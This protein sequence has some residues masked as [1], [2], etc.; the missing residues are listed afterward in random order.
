MFSPVG[1]AAGL[2]ARARL[3]ICADNNTVPFGLRKGT[4]SHGM[5]PN[6][7][8]DRSM[9]NDP[10]WNLPAVPTFSL[11]SADVTDGGEVPPELYSGFAGVPGGRD[12]SPQLSWEG[13]PAGTQSYVVTMFDPD[14]PT[15]SGYWHWAVLGIPAAV[16]SLP[17]GAGDISGSQLPSGAVQLRNDAG[18]AG[19]FGSA[20]PPGHG[21]HRYVIV[22]HAA[23][24]ADLG[25][26]VDA[27]PA[28]LGFALFTHT[29]ARAAITVIG[30]RAGY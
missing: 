7:R 16:T 3:R 29:L 15:G 19:F 25:V 14:A 27:S 26:S 4:S 2:T 28:A 6:A 9:S 17:R 20:P 18:L 13:A 22:V 10:F 23:D 12:I 11:S 21:P 5:M 1:A 8:Y 24:S 30:E